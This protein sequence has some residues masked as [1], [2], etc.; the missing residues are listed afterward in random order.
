VRGQAVRALLVH[1][2]AHLAPPVLTGGQLLQRLEHGARILPF[3]CGR[4]AT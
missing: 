2:Q 3:L 4:R 1:V